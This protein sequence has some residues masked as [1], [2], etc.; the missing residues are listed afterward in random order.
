MR[1][2][3]TF[4]AA[5]W[6][7]VLTAACGADH[8]QF[9]GAPMN[10]QLTSAAFADGQFIPQKFTCEGDDISPPLTWKNAPVGTKSFA[11]I[12]DD[13][14]APA[15]TWVHWVIWNLPASA[16]SLEENTPPSGSLA[17][18]ARQGLNDFHRLGY[19][20]PCPPPGKAHRYFFKL[21]A[22][23]AVLDLPSG[24]AKRDLLQ[25]MAGHVLAQGQLM[26]KYQ[27]K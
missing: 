5:V 15:G 11:L 3:Q 13:P 12:A 8:G 26:G 10:L 18:G 22:L 4:C 9:S 2:L 24:A 16:T 17:N 25:A 19:G 27:R 1:R 14:D 7:A 23:D 6:L 20:G 21:Y